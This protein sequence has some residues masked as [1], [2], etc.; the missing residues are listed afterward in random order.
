M[1]EA[2]TAASAVTVVTTNLGLGPD[3]D[4]PGGLVVPQAAPGMCTRS[5]ASCLM[6]QPL[7]VP[8]AQQHELALVGIPRVPTE[9]GPG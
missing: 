5:Q 4:H 2:T 1:A 7:A 3:P 8:G 6:S 9:T